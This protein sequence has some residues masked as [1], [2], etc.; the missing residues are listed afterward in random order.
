MPC[1]IEVVLNEHIFQQFSNYKRAKSIYDELIFYLNIVLNN[2]I[3]GQKLVLD[4][5]SHMRSTSSVC[6]VNNFFRNKSEL[7]NYRHDCDIKHVVVSSW[8]WI[9]WFFKSSLLFLFNELATATVFYL[10]KMTR[11]SFFYRSIFLNPFK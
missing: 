1:H 2:A 11:H 3:N 10:T 6:T 8:P 4:V 9:S 7:V 5:L